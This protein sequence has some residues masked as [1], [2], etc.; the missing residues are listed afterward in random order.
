MSDKWPKDPKTGKYPECCCQECGEFIGLIGRFS[1]AV[2]FFKFHLCRKQ[3]D[4]PKPID[5]YEQDEPHCPK[6]DSDMKEFVTVLQCRHCRHVYTK[7]F[8]PKG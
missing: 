8:P 7:R 4:E 2:L 1:E 3:E 5:V 6:C